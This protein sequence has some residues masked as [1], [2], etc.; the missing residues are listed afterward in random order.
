MRYRADIDGLR[1]I[2]VLS[3]V[4]GHAKFPLFGGGFVGVDIFFV[5]SGFLIT[6]LI[7]SEQNRGEFSLL[8]FYERRMRRIL[9]ALFVVIVT[10][11]ILGWFLSMPEDYRLIVRSAFSVLLFLSNMMFWREIGYFDGAAAEKP[12]L[13]TWSLS[14]EEQFYVV[15]PL[16]MM[17]MF[18]FGNKWRA[19]VLVGLFL[20]SLVASVWVTMKWPATGFYWSPLR[21]WELLAGSLLA[22]AITN[23]NLVSAIVRISVPL[24]I[25][26]IALI[27]LPI[28]FYTEAT[29]FPGYAAIPPVLGSVFLIAG[30]LAGRGTVWKLLSSKPM[31]FVGKRSYSLYLWHFPLFA[32]AFYLAQSTPSLTV[33]VV[34]IVLA[35]L[36]SMASYSFIEQPCRDRNFLSQLKVYVVSVSSSAALAAL[37][38]IIYFQNGVP[39]RF[40]GAAF[41]AVEAKLDYNHDRYDCFLNEQNKRSGPQLIEAACTVGQKNGLADFVLWGDSHAETYRTPFAKAADTLGLSGRY[42]GGDGCVPAV[43]AGY[44]LRCLDYNRRILDGI[45]ASGSVKTVVLVARWTLYLEMSV[46]NSS[47]H[48]EPLQPKNSTF[49]M[50]R[51]DRFQQQLDDLTKIVGKLKSAG[52]SV[53]VLAPLPEPGVDGPRTKFVASVGTGEHLNN[54]LSL[55]DFKTRALPTLELLEKV[56]TSLD[57]PLLY[58]HKM[59]CPKDKCLNTIGET[60]LY[61]DDDHLSREGAEH[62]SPLAMRALTN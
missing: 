25:I 19:Y 35:V 10:T 33:R 29:L 59:L 37:T 18:K 24:Q 55:E 14:V 48:Y 30:G 11:L 62:L 49:P 22:C 7:I 46:P 21:G 2:A 44:Y 58:P 32:F 17:L 27:T 13:H 1:T 51:E 47:L 16:L 39:N 28:V 57:V 40:D 4:F 5:I 42:V 23:Q 38:L 43:R 15:F 34:L 9:P 52:K 31:V 3:V 60:I 54:Q 26:G 41:A 20:L 50:D 36:L 45:V 56:A 6:G 12:L 61:H 53:V 8:S